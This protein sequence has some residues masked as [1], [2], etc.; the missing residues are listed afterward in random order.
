[1]DP[2]TSA[3]AAGMRAR[4]EA[5]DLLANNLANVSTP[6]YKAD[7]ES[8]SQYAA[9]GAFSV[10][11]GR[12][13]SPVVDHKWTDLS[14]GTFN[15]TGDPFDV[16]LMGP[17]FLVA[18]GPGGPLLTRGGS[19]QVD[20]A[21]RLVTKDGYE[22]QSVEDRA[23]TADRLF[24]ITIDNT[25]AVHQNGRMLG[26]LKTVQADGIESAGKRQGGYFAV[27]PTALRP[28]PEGTVEVRQGTLEAANLGAAEAA[29]RLVNV[30]RQFETLQK[31]LQL[32]G[33]MNLR[34]V[35]EVARIQS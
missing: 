34:A 35:E 3:A 6:G 29:V 11:L 22:L 25:G 23:I 7:R 21:G 13:F 1:M 26:R 20:G 14:Q 10:T 5:L 33:E 15:A 24:P 2:L 12:N 17:G 31:A 18:K 19:L 30:L 8:Y 28:A 32:G 4:M 16:A 9:E 27:D